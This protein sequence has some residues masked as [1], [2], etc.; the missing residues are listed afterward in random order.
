VS[1]APTHPWYDVAWPVLAGL[2]A[3]VGLVATYR[4]T[5]PVT[6][7]VALAVLELTVA[8]VAWSLLTELGFGVRRVALRVAPMTAVGLMAVIG[9]AETIGAWTCLVVALVVAASPLLRGFSHA[10]VR[11][12][13]AG[14]AGPQARTRREF[15]EIVAHGFGAPDDE[16]PR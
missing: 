6:F 3:G 8:P 5:G 11:G 15:E 2:V 14:W 4:W 12:L 16:L 13:A 9:L 7:L 10:G 1:L